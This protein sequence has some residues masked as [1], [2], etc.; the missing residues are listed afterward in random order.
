M[1]TKNQS[2]V[3]KNPLINI[4]V[5]TH[6]RPN[7]FKRAIQEIVKQSYKNVFI[8]VI[9]DDVASEKYAKKALDEGL[10]DDVVVV[11]PT[12][13]K[14]TFSFEKLIQQGLVKNKDR[15]QGIYNLYY[16]NVIQQIKEGWI[17]FFDDDFQFAN[18]N[19]LKNLASKL[20][21]EY[22]LVIARCQIGE[23]RI[24]PDDEYWKKLPV[25]RGQVSGGALCVHS[26][27]KDIIIWDGFKAGDYR[28][29]RRLTDKMEV[30]WYKAVLI[31]VDKEGF[32]RTEE[33]LN[34]K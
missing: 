16:N 29:V 2:S 8:I 30:T 20:T 15:N 22:N 32:G 31:V 33:Q 1:E 28:L 4:L 11:D 6:Q 9:A 14:H 10:V 34:K 26:I 24:V 23:N 27:H 17:L 7:L 18:N 5:R 19:S 21:N 12:L 13:L 3:E 25:T